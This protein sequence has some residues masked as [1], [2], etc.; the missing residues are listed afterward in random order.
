MI[1]GMCTCFGLAIY[2]LLSIVSI[3]DSVVFYDRE[4]ATSVFLAAQVASLGF[5]LHMRFQKSGK[6]TKRPRNR[7]VFENLDV[8][9]ISL[10]STKS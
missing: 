8:S 5:W 9:F 10:E 4:N 7:T 2:F 1:L 6:S 3:M